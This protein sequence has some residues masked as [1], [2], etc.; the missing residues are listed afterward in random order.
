LPKRNRVMATMDNINHRYSKG[1][2]SMTSA[3]L[4]GKSQSWLLL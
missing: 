3:G 1:A 2:L 4:A